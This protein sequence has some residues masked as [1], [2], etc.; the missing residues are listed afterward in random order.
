MKTTSK[1]I[2]AAASLAIAAGLVATIASP[3]NA[4][5]LLGKAELVNAAGATVGEV[6]FKGRHHRAERVTVTLRLPAYAP[7]LGSY[8]GLHVHASGVCVAPFTS[9]AGHWNLTPETTHGAHTG[10][11]PP[12]LVAADGTARAEFETQRFDVSQLFDADGS[13]VILHSGPDN[14]GNVPIAPDKYQDP[15]NWYGAPTG[16]ANTGD[17]GTRYACGVVTSR[18]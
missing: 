12:I 4:S 17:A 1:L 10:D 18:R 2:G 13:A 6:T 5:R 16:T 3:A 11:L 9:A 15:F 7:G 14:L 8:H